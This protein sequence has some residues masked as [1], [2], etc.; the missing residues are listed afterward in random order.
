MCSVR[1]SVED[2]LGV[3]ER[4]RAARSGA[5]F[6][7][8]VVDPAQP[9]DRR[10]PPPTS[11]CARTARCAAARELATGEESAAEPAA[12]I[13][14]AVDKL[15]MLAAARGRGYG[16][17][18]GA[19]PARGERRQHARAAPPRCAARS[20]APSSRRRRAAAA[21]SPRPAPSVTSAAIDSGVA[22]ASQSRPQWL[23]SSV[24][25]PRRAREPQRG[26]VEHAV[27]RAVERRRAPG[28]SLDRVLA[29]ARGP[30]APATASGA[31]GCG[32]GRS[33]A[34][35]RGRRR[36]S[37]R[38]QRRVA[39]DL[40]ADEEE[41]RARRRSRGEDLEHRRACPAACGPSSKVSA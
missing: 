7:D 25:Q 40:L 4:E 36:R 32:G 12:S 37:R 31:A 30:R 1:S 15:S 14:T 39:P 35:S 6:V 22:R 34:R 9:D 33:A 41:R 17:R 23:H 10:A 19:Q 28:A 16:R 5:R 20:P 13:D 29:R 21:P 18:S 24:R 26:G 38:A 27:G 3:G 2:A 8:R 11:A